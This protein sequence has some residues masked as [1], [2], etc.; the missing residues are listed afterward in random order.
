MEQFIL[1]Y[2]N[3][4]ITLSFIFNRLILVFISIEKQWNNY[5][6]NYIKSLAH[7]SYSLALIDYLLY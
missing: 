2:Y 7:I 1:H 6:F 5:Y 4:Y 3:N